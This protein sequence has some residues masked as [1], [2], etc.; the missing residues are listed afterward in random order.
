MKDAAQALAALPDI[1]A[2]HSEAKCPG[3]AEALQTHDVRQQQRACDRDVAVAIF[4]LQGFIN[5]CK[6]E[7]GAMLKAWT[8]SKGEAPSQRRSLAKQAA[9]T[10]A[11]PAKAPLYSRSA[12]RRLLCKGLHMV[13]DMIC[14][15]RRRWDTILAPMLEPE[16]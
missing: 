6:V 14:H 16:G 8:S 12:V 13:E 15:Y 11:Q 3:A 7:D 2:M 9:R 5:A 10:E 1:L 4:T